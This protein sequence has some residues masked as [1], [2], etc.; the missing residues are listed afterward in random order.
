MIISCSCT[1]NNTIKKFESTFHCLTPPPGHA[2]FWLSYTGEI[3]KMSFLTL[4]FRFMPLEPFSFD[5]NRRQAFRLFLFSNVFDHAQYDFMTTPFLN[6]Q[7]YEMNN[8]ILSA[9]CFYFLVLK[10]YF[11][12]ITRRKIFR[13]FWL[14]KVC[15]HAQSDF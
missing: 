5:I 13:L 10:P 15:D 4:K 14:S 9:F 1:S 12:N 3:V 7:N 8:S 11:F 2:L 6:R